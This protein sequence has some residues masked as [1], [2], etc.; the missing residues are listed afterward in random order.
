MKSNL[1]FAV[2]AI[3]LLVSSLA[4][5]MLAANN[6]ASA[7]TQSGN[8]TMSKNMTSAGGMMAKNATK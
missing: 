1:K 2:F 6:P 8:Q 3:A 7:A 5:A 4:G